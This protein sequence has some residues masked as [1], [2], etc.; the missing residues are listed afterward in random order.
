[1]LTADQRTVF[2]LD[3]HPDLELFP[4]LFEKLL[5]NVFPSFYGKTSFYILNYTFDSQELSLHTLN[6]KCHQFTWL[7][8]PREDSRSSTKSLHPSH[9]HCWTSPRCSH[10]VGTVYRVKFLHLSGV[11][12]HI[13]SIENHNYIENPPKRPISPLDLEFDRWSWLWWENEKYSITTA[14]ITTM[15]FD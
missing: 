15:G 3:F 1:M 10:F 5:K 6:S 13:L 12:H 7:E 4:P 11:L 2:F 8:L 9:S 14:I